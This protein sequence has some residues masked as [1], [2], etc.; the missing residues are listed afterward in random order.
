MLPPK[1]WD[2]MTAAEQWV[3][4]QY[5][6]SLKD[7]KEEAIQLVVSGIFLI[8]F[9]ALVLLFKIRRFREWVFP[10]LTDAERR[11]FEALLKGAEDVGEGV[12]MEGDGG[13]SDNEGCLIDAMYRRFKHSWFRSMGS[14]T[15]IG[16]GGGYRPKDIG[17][18]DCFGVLNITALAIIT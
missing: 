10:P 18:W 2:Q 6:K 7:E 9:V 11:R 8:A 14:M 16:R 15:W 12:L 5:E 1:P 17:G 13:V 4:Q 3:Q